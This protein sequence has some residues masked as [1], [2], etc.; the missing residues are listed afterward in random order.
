MIG[1]TEGIYLDQQ[2]LVSEPDYRWLPESVVLVD[3]GITEGTRIHVLFPLWGRE[4]L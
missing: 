3:R 1:Q 4:R 2:Y